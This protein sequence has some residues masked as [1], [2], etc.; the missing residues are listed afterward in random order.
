MHE[1]WLAST[2]FLDHEHPTVRD[3]ATT[4]AAGATDPTEIAVRLF[5]AVR[6]GWRY[7]PYD[8]SH[9]PADYRASAI[10]GQN[11][12]WCV[13]K[14]VLLTA[15]AR[16]MGIPARLGFADVKN[17]LTTEKL[18][19]RMGTAAQQQRPTSP[20]GRCLCSPAGRYRTC[21][22]RS[23]PSGSS[24]SGSVPEPTPSTL[25]GRGRLASTELMTPPSATRF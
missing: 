1:R 24:S 3:F 5:H 2:E 20:A 13:S 12:G 15:S 4:A 6:D 14:S 8:I 25:A 21:G 23:S 11:R 18:G 10:A 22:H 16:A 17:H 7:D 19:E 9:D